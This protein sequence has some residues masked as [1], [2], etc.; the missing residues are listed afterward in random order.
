[1]QDAT[2]GMRILRHRIMAVVQEILRRNPVASGTLQ[3]GQDARLFFW[4]FSVATGL[5]RKAIMVID[6]ETAQKEPHQ[7]RRRAN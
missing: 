7:R 5:S 3:G 6:G 2:L 1:M 4:F